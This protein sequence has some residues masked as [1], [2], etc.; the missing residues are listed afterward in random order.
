MHDSP[1]Y[2]M[3]FH[4]DTESE[5][6]QFDDI[7]IT[8]ANN[9]VARERDST[10][11]DCDLTEWTEWS[12]CSQACGKHAFQYKRRTIAQKPENGG[13]ECPFKLERKRKCGVPK[14][15]E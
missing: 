12:V 8:H 3:I 2:G 1:D 7:L 6:K 5:Q 13:K 15:R 11:K 4:I 9:N 14:C 10:V